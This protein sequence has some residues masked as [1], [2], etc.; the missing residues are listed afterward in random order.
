MTDFPVLKTA[1]PISVLP[2]LP[3]DGKTGATDMLVFI[4]ITPTVCLDSAPLWRMSRLDWRVPATNIHL[5]F[6]F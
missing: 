2:G 4:C 5:I 3:L 6:R 1:S